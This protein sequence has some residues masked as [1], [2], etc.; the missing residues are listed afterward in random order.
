[1]SA[2]SLN[3]WPPFR[4]S[5]PDLIEQSPEMASWSTAPIRRLPEAA[6]AGYRRRIYTL[7]LERVRPRSTWH[8]RG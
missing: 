2:F 3:D 6:A 8:Y 7:L 4:Q 5:A 1:M